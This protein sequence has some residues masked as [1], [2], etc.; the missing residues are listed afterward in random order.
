MGQKVSCGRERPPRKWTLKAYEGLTADLVTRFGP[1]PLM[2]ANFN[3]INVNPSEILTELLGALDE[4][5][6][7]ESTSIWLR[8]LLATLILIWGYVKKIR[9]GR[10]YRL[11]LRRF[12]IIALLVEALH[13]IMAKLVEF[14]EVIIL[15]VEAIE[16]LRDALDCQGVKDE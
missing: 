11:V 4:A 3:A 5:A 10:V 12:I 8:G 14:V 2:C 7:E 6:G 13:L 15:H 9:T 1:K 16:A